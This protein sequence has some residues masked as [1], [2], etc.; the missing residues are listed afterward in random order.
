MSKVRV[1]GNGKGAI[2]VPSENNPEYGFIRVQQERETFGSPDAEHPTGWLQ[3]KTLSALVPGTVK[4]LK[5]LGWAEGQ[6]IPGMIV[7]REQFL[8]FNTVNPE[9]NLKVAGDTG[10]V[11]TKEG[12]KIFRQSFYTPNTSA[13][14]VLIQ[15]DNSAEIKA[16]AVPKEEEESFKLD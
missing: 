1:S 16:A 6:E 9:K 14:D 4:D 12:Q 5:R 13:Q 3:V 8:P 7:V 11:C 15:H 10:V 2:V